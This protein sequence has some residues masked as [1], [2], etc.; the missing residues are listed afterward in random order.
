MAEPTMSLLV[1][2][3]L[4]LKGFAETK[5]IADFLGEPE[6]EVKAALDGAAE[7]GHASYRDGPRSGWIL[8][9]EG[10]VENE[11]L[12]KEQLEAA[13][14]RETVHACYQRFLGLNGQMLAACTNWQ[15][16]DADA[17]ILN[18]HSDP[19]YDEAVI[20]EL[21]QIDD[22]VQPICAC[23]LYTSPSPRDATLSRM[24]S[25]A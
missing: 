3:G 9:K 17:Q 19:A 13:G 8:T 25:S 11:R 16:S 2:H 7:A 5:V 21:T 20:G 12:L 6:N 22:S 23:L 15:V 18:D 4:R 24:P 14:Q 10:R 1:L